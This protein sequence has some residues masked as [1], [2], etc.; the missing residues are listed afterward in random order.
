[1]AVQNVLSH[2]H[3]EPEETSF[4]FKLAQMGLACG[5]LALAPAAGFCKHCAG[6]S[7]RRCVDCHALLPN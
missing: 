5:L 3:Q 7:R 2:S 6:L 1:M 4:L